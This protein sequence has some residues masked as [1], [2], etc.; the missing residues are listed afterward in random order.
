MLSEF[1]FLA[2]A[3]VSLVMKRREL[4]EKDLLNM[5]H[6]LCRESVEF[7]GSKLCGENM[8]TDMKQVYE[9]SR[10]SDDFKRNVFTT[11]LTPDVISHIDWFTFGASTNFTFWCLK[12]FSSI[13]FFLASFHFIVYN[14]STSFPME[15]FYSGPTGL[16]LLSLSENIV[17]LLE[18]S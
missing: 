13:I 16:S 8:N 4:V 6:D 10:T 14:I 18:F 11:V 12:Y 7:S 17:K 1:R 3:N 2:S 5:Y 9:L 15:N